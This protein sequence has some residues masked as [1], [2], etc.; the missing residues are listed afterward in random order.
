MTYPVAEWVERHLRTDDAH[1]LA[2]CPV[3][4]GPTGFDAHRVL[5]A[6]AHHLDRIYAELNLDDDASQAWG[7]HDL[8]QA[9]IFRDALESSLDRVEPAVGE[10]VRR[11]TSEVDRWYGSWTEADPATDTSGAWWQR[12]PSR[13]PVHAELVAYYGHVHRDLTDGRRG[14]PG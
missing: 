3:A 11:I 5:F 7:P 2:G 6:W 1:E 14:T 13:G 4:L 8:V 9:L 12:L 10:R